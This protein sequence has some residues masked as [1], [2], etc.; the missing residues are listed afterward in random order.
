[1]CVFI[2][3]NTYRFLIYYLFE[4]GHGHILHVP[5]LSDWAFWQQMK[6]ENKQQMLL[7]FYSIRRMDTIPNKQKEK[8][9]NEQLHQKYY[10]QHIQKTKW[11]WSWMSSICVQSKFQF[12]NNFFFKKKNNWKKPFPIV[13]LKLTGFRSISR[14]LFTWYHFF[15]LYES[16]FADINIL[17]THFNWDFEMNFIEK[18]RNFF[19][20]AS[21]K[22]DREKKKHSWPTTTKW[23]ILTKFKANM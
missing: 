6:C 15:Y 12:N 16:A 14:E 20:R 11:N 2:E 19:F 22:N 5:C 1:M 23:T 17:G 3:S 18:S 9:N 10:V 4:Y 13:C 8:K 7:L 21:G